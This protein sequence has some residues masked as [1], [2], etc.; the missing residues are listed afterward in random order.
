MSGT[1]KARRFKG[2]KGQESRGE[3]RQGR[4]RPHL[5]LH[6]AQPLTRTRRGAAMGR[7]RPLRTTGQRKGVIGGS[8]N[9]RYLLA[10]Q[11][12]RRNQ[13]TGQGRN[14]APISRRRDQIASAESQIGHRG[15]SFL[16]FRVKG[17]KEINRGLVV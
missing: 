4:E 2:R 16:V 5:V 15:L 9:Y 17:G 1:G 10:S 13:F 6:I 14:P 11:S 3:A 12:R 7:S 8:E